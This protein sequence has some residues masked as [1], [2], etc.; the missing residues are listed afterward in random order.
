MG[1][2]LGRIEGLQVDYASHGAEALHVCREHTAPIELLLTD[3][4]MPGMSGRE[5]ARHLVALRPH[6]KV[7][8]MSGYSDDALGNHGVLDPDIL[9]LAKPFT[10]ESLLGALRRALDAPS[11]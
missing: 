8:Y 10:P 6:I 7:L 1:P 11:P 3:V 5:L 4:V 2:V 9:L